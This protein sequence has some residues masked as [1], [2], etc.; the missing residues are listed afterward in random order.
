MIRCARDVPGVE[1]LET[2]GVFGLLLDFP[3]LL[4]GP[5]M[6]NRRKSVDM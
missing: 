3:F 6:S 1:E 4:P 5:G 2:T